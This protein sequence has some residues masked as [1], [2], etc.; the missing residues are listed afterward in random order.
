M[1]YLLI[2]LQNKRLSI[3]KELLL[4]LFSI[5][6]NTQDLSL[7]GYMIYI[8]YSAVF[9]RPSYVVPHI[10]TVQSW[11]TYMGY[12]QTF[13]QVQLRLKILYCGMEE[14]IPL[15]CMTLC[16]MH[17]DFLDE[18]R[19]RLL[20]TSSLTCAFSH[21]RS[22]SLRQNT[23]FLSLTWQGER[24]CDRGATNCC[25]FISC[26]NCCVSREIGEK[27]WRVPCMR[28]RERESDRG[29]SDVTCE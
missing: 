28:E 21:A 17:P 19:W 22:L 18:T 8:T 16:D 26:K 1:D 15:L 4:Q 20:S 9:Y 29:G 2:R 6:E 12:V 10:C 25:V 14:V 24:G 11:L 27:K 7:Q 13:G 3:F 5:H 23:L